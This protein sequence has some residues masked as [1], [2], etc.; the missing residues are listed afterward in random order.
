MSIKNLAGLIIGLVFL[1]FSFFL[2]SKVI[3][4]NQE[5]ILLAIL[6]ILMT[7]FISYLFIITAL[8]RLEYEILEKNRRVILNESTKNIVVFD[9]KTKQKEILNNKTINTIELY[10]SC[11]TNPFSPDL[12]FSKFVMKTGKT[13]NI[14]QEI[15][16]QSKIQYIFRNKVINKKSRFM[17]RLK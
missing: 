4:N 8:Y 11:N 5:N 1:I 10:Y 2:T 15:V 13:I 7:Y 3:Q 9:K 17:N 14:T 6:V 12:G 16:T